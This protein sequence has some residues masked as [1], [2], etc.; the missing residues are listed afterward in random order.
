MAW[1]KRTDT[2]IEVPAE[3]RVRTEGLWVKCDGCR[4]IIW[5]KDLEGN[6]NVCPKC[7]F[8][9]RID[10]GS[11]LRLLF[12]EGAYEEYDSDLRS[13]DP[14]GFVDSKPYSERLAR[15]SSPACT[16]RANSAACSD[17]SATVS[18]T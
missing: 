8:H 3:K 6:W 1:F 11:R 7:G 4:Q 17:E 9:T 15:T 16:P 12:D 5:K 14:L 10:A 2:D 18:A 13:S